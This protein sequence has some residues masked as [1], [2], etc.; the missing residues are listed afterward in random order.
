MT[1]DDNHLSEIQQVADRLRAAG[2]QVEQVLEVTGVITG[3]IPESQ[4][5]AL[6]G[7]SGVAD[8]EDEREHKHQRSSPDPGIE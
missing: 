5:T 7:V 4:K 3:S 2:M 6:A 1:V 8:V